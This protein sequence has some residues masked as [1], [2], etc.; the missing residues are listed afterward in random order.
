MAE[1]VDAT[2]LEAVALAWEFESPLGHHFCSL[3]LVVRMSPFHGENTSSNLVGNANFVSIVAA[4][5]QPRKL[6]ESNGAR[7]TKTAT[8]MYLL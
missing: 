3:H 2:V 7:P 5:M 6:H 8:D 1:L 4:K